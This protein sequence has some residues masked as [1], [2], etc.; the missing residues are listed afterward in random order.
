MADVELRST[1]SDRFKPLVP[2]CRADLKAAY[3]N[4]MVR[5]PGEA[6]VQIRKQHT[7]VLLNAAGEMVC[8]GSPALERAKSLPAP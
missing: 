3:E 4:T 2:L 7:A 1:L 5:F 6:S 8:F